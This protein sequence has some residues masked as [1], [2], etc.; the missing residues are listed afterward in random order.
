MKKTKIV[1]TLGPATVKKS[2][3]KMMIRS[4]MNSAR[5]NLSH[6]DFTDYGRF[7]KI[8]RSI[9]EIPIILDSKGR[10]VRIITDKPLELKRGNLVKF[11]FHRKFS[12]YLDH[13]FSNEAKPGHRIFFDD[14]IIHAKIEEI[15]SD[16]AI[17]RCQNDGIL[18]SGKRLNLPD[19]KLKLP[20]LHAKDIEGINF[21]AKNKIEFFALSFTTCKNDVLHLKKKL[22]E[23]GSKTSVIA[24]I[25]NSEG[26]DNF[27]EILKVS[28]GI[29]IARGD[30]GVELPSEKIPLLQKEMIR[31]CYTHGKIVI[32]ATQMLQ[33]MVEST[34][35]TRAE[36][37]DVANAILDGTDAVMLSAETAIGKYPVLAVMEM[38]KIAKEV[39]EK[40]I[41]NI[42]DPKMMD[43]TE[44]ISHSSYALQKAIPIDKMIVLTSSGYTARMMARFRIAKDIIAI[45]PNFEVKKRL[46]MIFGLTPVYYPKFMDKDKVIIGARIAFKK[47]LVKADDTVL[48]TAGLYTRGKAV[49]NLIEIHKISDLIGHFDNKEKR[50]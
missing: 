34:T 10:E 1:C 21:A 39:E 49:T 8:I 16:Y 28:D 31:K 33:S 29:M 37:S 50:T 20:S 48:F 24:K 6:G 11:G 19:T 46:E 9:S 38:S 15:N 26:I 18:K 5:I 14:G 45:T 23:T 32:T 13:N 27:D 25:E 40:I 30:L 47:K 3:L 7:V 17:I 44:A 35:P 12:A 36:T 22:K 4:G 41:V 42:H 43:V 2:V